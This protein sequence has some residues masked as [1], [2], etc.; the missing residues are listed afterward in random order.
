M[1]LAP[2][3]PSFWLLCQSREC[4]SS[5]CHVILF[6]QGH[7]QRWLIFLDD[8]AELHPGA[9][10]IILLEFSSFPPRTRPHRSHIWL[11]TQ[12]PF[13]FHSAACPLHCTNHRGSGV[14]NNAP[15]A[16]HYLS[17]IRPEPARGLISFWY[18]TWGL[19]S[20]WYQ[21]WGLISFWYHTCDGSGFE[22]VRTNY[23]QHQTA[24][25][26]FSTMGEASH[27]CRFTLVVGRFD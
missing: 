8:W 21:T 16:M 11:N 27:L 25:Q 2:S 14:G 24:L 12:H 26:M 19:I 22:F 1:A 23:V 7:A 17:D 4:W 13:V 20:F 10:L 3:A 9:P 6:F 15:L 18:Q 5:Q